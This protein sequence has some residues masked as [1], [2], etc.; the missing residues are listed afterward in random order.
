MIRAWILGLLFT[1]GLAMASTVSGI[2]D[3]FTWGVD[4]SPWHVTG[5]VVV[6]PGSTLTVSPGVDVLFDDNVEFIVL[7]TLSAQGTETDSVIFAAGDSTW[8]GLRVFGSASMQWTKISGAAGNGE[9]IDTLVSLL[10]SLATLDSTDINRLLDLELSDLGLPDSLDLSSIDW[11]SFVPDDLPL[12]TGA[13]YISVLGPAASLV[14]QNCLV[15]NNH[16]DGIGGVI[17]AGGAYANLGRSDIQRNTAALIPGVLYAG[18]AFGS[19]NHVDVINNTSTYALGGVAILGSDVI[20]NECRIRDNYLGSRLGGAFMVIDTCTV[21][22]IRCSAYKNTT[23]GILGAAVFAGDARVTM[24]STFFA[25]NSARGLASGVSVLFGADVTMRDCG[26]GANITHDAENIDVGFPLPAAAIGGGLVVVDAR[27]TMEDCGIESN[28]TGAFTGGGLLVKTFGYRDAVVHMTRT[29]IHDNTG[30][31]IVALGPLEGE[32]DSLCSVTLVN[33]TVA[34]NANRL[35]ILPISAGI[36]SLSGATVILENSIVWHNTAPGVVTDIMT[37]AGITDF[38]VSPGTV[39]A[40]YSDIEVVVLDPVYPGIG[41]IAADPM[42]LNLF[43]RFYLTEASPCLDAGNPDR[44]DPDA[45]RSNMGAS[46]LFIPDAIT[47]VAEPGQLKLAQNAPNPFNPMT[48][49]RFATPRGG[50]VRIVIYNHLGQLVN[51]LGD[52]TYSAGIHEVRW[53]GRDMMRR[54]AASGA[55]LYRLTFD[56]GLRQSSLVRRMLLVR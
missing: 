26:I 54:Q 19:M 16:A 31:G 15:E 32:A 7:G 9:N 41:N 24:E 36:Y 43:S 11:E 35:G 2:P 53:N 28:V 5:T 49:I 47:D 21:E 8:K 52:R 42:F 12:I 37:L 18:R 20:M 3:V 34:R 10:D 4:G 27:V 48:N 39:N 30:G 45:T 56:D 50:N 1:A 14:M 23:D 44:T 51:V 13:G 33:C 55:Y 6:P 40:T 22:I 25:A 29:I 38:T 46:G 17:I